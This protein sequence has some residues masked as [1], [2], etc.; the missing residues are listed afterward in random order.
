MPVY[1]IVR[2]YLHI[3]VADVA[4][5]ENITT[6]ALS[7]IQSAVTHVYGNALANNSTFHRC[8]FTT[9]EITTDRAASH[10]IYNTTEFEGASRVSDF[11]SGVVKGKPRE[12][13]FTQFKLQT[14]TLFGW[15]DF[16]EADESGTVSTRVF[17]DEGSAEAQQFA[18]PNPQ[19]FRVVFSTAP[20]LVPLGKSK[21]KPQPVYSMNYEQI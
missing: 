16:A 8:L 17:N 14:R 3:P 5:S 11:T 19:D 20:S 13:E 15:E 1:R 7:S 10:A 2:A 4:D 12:P 18:Q 9:D 21:P 6:E